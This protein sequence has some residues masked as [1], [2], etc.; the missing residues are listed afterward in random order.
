[1]ITNA[2]QDFLNYWEIKRTQNKNN[3]I[4]FIKGFSLG[5]FFGSLIIVM[6]GVGWYQRANMVAS[7]K[8]NP[9]ILITCI[10]L[11]AVFLSIIYNNFKWE[12]NEQYYKELLYKKRKES[13]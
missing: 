11:I 1:M 6:L 9:A 2:E 10:I 8:L 3:P 13:Q 5:L 7:A 12:Q 4:L